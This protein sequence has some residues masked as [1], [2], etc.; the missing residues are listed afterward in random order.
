MASS[1]HVRL[2]IAFQGGH[3]IGPLVAPAAADELARALAG[4]PDG[5]FELEAEDGKYVIPLRGVL[6]LKRFSRE[7]QIGFGRT[8]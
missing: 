6:Y 8:G 5:A 7:S 2:E 3:T 4:A 1:E